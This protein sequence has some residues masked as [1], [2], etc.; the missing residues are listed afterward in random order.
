M[1]EPAMRSAT[2]RETS[3]SPGPGVWARRRGAFRR[4]SG[5]EAVDERVI[6]QAADKHPG[7]PHC[8][9]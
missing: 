4:R 5:L 7:D 9:S 2:V 6:D 8:G 3:T 1:S